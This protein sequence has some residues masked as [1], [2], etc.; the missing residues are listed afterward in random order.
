MTCVL[1]EYK[2]GG[3]VIFPG[4]GNEQIFG[5]WGDFLNSHIIIALTPNTPTLKF[6]ILLP[7]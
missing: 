3:E 7:S 5:W 6:K 2:I 4:G 1:T